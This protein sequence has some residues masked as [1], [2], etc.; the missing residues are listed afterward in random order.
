MPQVPFNK[1]NFQISPQTFF[2]SLYQSS[3]FWG[4]SPFF[5]SLTP[6]K[7]EKNKKNFWW[8]TLRD[9]PFFL[10]GVFFSQIG[11][12]K[13]EIGVKIFLTPLFF[14]RGWEKKDPFFFLFFEIQKRKKSFWKKKIF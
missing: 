3:F 8:Q 9:P 6:W 10:H 7:K 4:F 14:F 11:N 1:Q 5:P 13:K 12:L 2:K